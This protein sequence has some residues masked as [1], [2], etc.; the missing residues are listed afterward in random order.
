MGN[1]I[2]QVEKTSDEIL[3]ELMQERIYSEETAGPIQVSEPK[4]QETNREEEIITPKLS[5]EEL[6]KKIE[7]KSYD[8]GVFLHWKKQQSESMSAVTTAARALAI[9]LGKT[10]DAEQAEAIMGIYED[11]DKA[12]ATYIE[13]HHPK[14]T[15]GKAR[16]ALV[17]KIYERVSEEHRRAK[18]NVEILKSEKEKY[19]GQTWEQ[20]LIGEKVMTLK[21]GQLE[22]PEGITSAASRVMTF[23]EGGKDYFFKLREVVPAHNMESITRQIVA[24]Y[25]EELDQLFLGKKGAYPKLSPEERQKRIDAIRAKAISIEKMKDVIKAINIREHCAR[26]ASG[27]WL[28]LIAKAKASFTNDDRDVFYEFFEIFKKKATIANVAED[29]GIRPG[30]ELGVRNEATSV[31]A[32]FLGISDMMMKSTVITVEVEGKQMRG[33]RMDKVEGVAESKMEKVKEYLNHEAHLSP[34]A[35]NQFMKLQVF[36]II[37]G[38]TDRNYG[39]YL[40]QVSVDNKAETTAFGTKGR[41]YVDSLVGIDNDI[42]FGTLSYNEIVSQKAH[43]GAPGKIRIKRMEDEHNNILIPALDSEF[44]EK[45]LAMRPEMIELLFSRMLSPDEILAIKDR[46]K[47]VQQVIERMKEHDKTAA[48]EEKLLLSSE[49]EWKQRLAEL[50]KLPKSAK[51]ESSTTTGP[52]KVTEKNTV[53]KIASREDMGNKTYVYNTYLGDGIYVTGF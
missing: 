27:V 30:S 51:P 1:E 7:D 48:P 46:L 37:C 8:R 21:S 32:D 6:A 39:N 15:E 29:A 41:V 43:G 40:F 52:K 18:V 50:E 19:A 36:D 47:G 16:L 4:E 26:S 31:M 5:Y 23:S 22:E 9:M 53:K 17:K 3:H 12:C 2:K 28:E 45:I 38:Q 10:A 24:E 33:L 14:S 20:V 34:K 42:S 25:K 44:A 35:L 11:L 49:E 13:G